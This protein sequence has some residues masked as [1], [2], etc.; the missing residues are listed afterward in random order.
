MLKGNGKDIGEPVLAAPFFQAGYAEFIRQQQA[1]A[2]HAEPGAALVHGV[3]STG[4]SRRNSA[5]DG[6]PFLGW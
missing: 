6:F 1:D 2:E 5:H 3:K 4:N